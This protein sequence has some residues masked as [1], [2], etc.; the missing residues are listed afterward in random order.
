MTLG[1]MTETGRAVVLPP[2]R[3]IR[4]CPSY[5]PGR[6]PIG[7]DSVAVRV[8]GEEAD[9]VYAEAQ[10]I[11]A[12]RFGRRNRRECLKASGRRVEPLREPGRTTAPA[13]R[14]IGQFACRRALP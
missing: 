14:R 6:A 5:R 7:T 10:R 1:T 8:A 12:I 11:K 2:V 3:V 4:I 13:A 9:A